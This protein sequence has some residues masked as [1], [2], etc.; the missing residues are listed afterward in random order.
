MPAV[1]ATPT[2][3]TAPV[4]DTT[5]GLWTPTSAARALMLYNT[6]GQ[7][8]YVAFN[9]TTA[10]AAVFDIVPIANGGSAH[11]HAYSDLGIDVIS[12]VSV[13][14]PSG[15]TVGNFAIRTA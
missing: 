9:G 10:T 13:W 1:Y 8:I 15:A 14:F 7:T 11:Y 5:A 6:S 3:T 2:Q 4:A 12:S